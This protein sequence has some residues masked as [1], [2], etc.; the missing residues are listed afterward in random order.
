MD[1]PVVVGF[2]DVPADDGGD[3]VTLLRWTAEVPR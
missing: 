2:E 1:L 3:A